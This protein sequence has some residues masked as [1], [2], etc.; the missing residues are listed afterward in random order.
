MK[1]KAIIVDDEKMARALLQGMIEEFCPEIQICETCVDLPNAIKA[2]HKYKPDL[3]FLDIEMPGHSGLELLDFFDENDINFSIIFTTAYNHYAIDAFKLSAIDYI[4][5][6]IETQELE[7][8]VNRFVKFK[9]KISHEQ[10]SALQNNL[11]SLLNKKIA[12]HTVSSIRLLK[13]DEISFFKADGAYTEIYMNS[14]EKIVSSKG[15]KHFEEAT[16]QFYHFFRCHKS[17]I[18]N[19]NEIVEYVKSDGGHLL[20]KNKLEVQFSSEKAAEIQKRLGLN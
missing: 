19:L 12:I 2:I 15:L 7:N 17:F 20:M 14:G 11:H 5:K 3:V 4:L 1:F 13:I 16:N 9:N 6:P 18:A 10:K 8:S